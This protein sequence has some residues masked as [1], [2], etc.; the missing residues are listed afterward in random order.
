M[1]HYYHKIVSPWLRTDSKSKI[2][3]L[4]SSVAK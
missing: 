2:V 3:D 4:E 1:A